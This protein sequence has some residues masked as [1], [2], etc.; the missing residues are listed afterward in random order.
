MTH[1]L[2]Q[3]LTCLCT[4]TL[5]RLPT[6]SPY[7]LLS[8]L[9]CESR[10]AYFATQY[11]MAT[12]TKSK[13]NV[14]KSPTNTSALSV[15]LARTETTTTATTS[16]Q[17]N[18]NKSTFII[19]STI[20]VIFWSY[21]PMTFSTLRLSCFIK[22]LKPFHIQNNRTLGNSKRTLSINSVKITWK[23]IK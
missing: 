5:I 19:F 8:F 11:N 20:T 16:E 6:P 3:L 10:F 21:I 12:R 2:T 9:A 14:R 18:N 1:L 17:E 15:L 13:S 4:D 23:S 22:T 7:T